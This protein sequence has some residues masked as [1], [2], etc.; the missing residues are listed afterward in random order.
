[1]PELGIG[2]NELRTDG[3]FYKIFDD[4]LLTDEEKRRLSIENSNAYFRLIEKNLNESAID[5]FDIRRLESIIKEA[6]PDQSIDSISPD[7]ERE[8][9]KKYFFIRI[10][11]EVVNRRNEIVS[12]LF[13]SNANELITLDFSIRTIMGQYKEGEP[14]REIA[15]R[16]HEELEKDIQKHPAYVAY[17]QELRKRYWELDYEYQ[18][19]SSFGRLIAKLKGEEKEVLRAKYEAEN[20]MWSSHP[21]ESSKD[22]VNSGDDQY[23]FNRLKSSEDYK[24]FSDEQVEEYS[25]KIAKEEWDK[26]FEKKEESTEQSERSYF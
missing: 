13:S 12:N 21:G 11:N 17:R 7:H 19:K 20:Q 26:M 2:R 25:R 9:R 4:T 6:M 14:L 23:Q 8:E 3:L 10:I 22:Y 15:Q 18:K 24:D 5:N 16:I 1:M